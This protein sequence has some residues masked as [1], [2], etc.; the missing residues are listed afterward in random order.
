MKQL[1]EHHSFTG[2]QRDMSISKH[3][4]S[5]LYDAHNI[6][7]TAR[8]EDT[9][10]TITNERGPSYAGVEI[11]GTYLG[12]CLLGKYLVIFS[13][14]GLKEDDN[15]PE[16]IKA[17]DDYIT[18]IDLSTKESVVLYKGNLE[19]DTNHPIETIGSYE[20]DKIQKIYWTDGKNQ[21]R[22]INIVGE[23]KE[24]IDTQFDFI[25]ELALQEEVTIQKQLGS[26]GSFAPGVIQY[27]FTYYNKHG[28]ETNIFYTSPL[29]YISHKDR[30]GSPEDK[31]ENAFKITLKNVDK[32]FDYIRIYSIQRTSIDA[33]PIVK[34]V[35]D[36]NIKAESTTVRSERWLVSNYVKIY[37]GSTELHPSWVWGDDYS[38]LSEK[39]SPLIFDNIQTPSA[40]FTE[41]LYWY[42]FTKSDYP[43]L[44]IR[45]P[46]GSITWEEG[47][48]NDST[49]W[50]SSIFCKVPNATPEDVFG[51][52]ILQTIDSSYT[53]SVD[54]KVH[55]DALDSVSFLDV[56]T[57]GE[58]VD[59]TELLYKGGESIKVQTIDQKDGTLFLGNIETERKLIDSQ[60]KA[61]IKSEAIRIV[62]D[63]V[64]SEVRTFYPTVV[65]KGDYL[66]H[67]QLTSYADSAKTISVPCGGFK[68]GD[69]YRCGVQF[70]Y[71]DGRWS[72]PIFLNDEQVLAKPN[73]DTTND[74]ISVPV[75]KYKIGNTNN[76]LNTLYIAGYRKLRPVVV[77][78]S[79]QDRVTICQG[80]TNP[81]LCFNH[82][83]NGDFHT[84]S[85]VK[86]QSSW[87]F[88]PSIVGTKTS[89]INNNST[90]SPYAGSGDDLE[91][92]NTCEKDGNKFT[93]STDPSYFRLIEIQG[94]FEDSDKLHI[95]SRILSMHSPDIEF[96]DSLYNLNFENTIIRKVGSI[97]FK[98]T[99]SDINIQTE[100]PQVSNSSFGFTHESF[101][102]NGS[103]GIVA[104]LFYEDFALDDADGRIQQWSE[105]HS[106]FKWMVYPWQR[107][108][109]LNNDITR[110]QDKGT[111]TSVLKK[112]VISN[113]RYAQSELADSSNWISYNISGNPQVYSSDQP[114]IVKVNE[115][116][117][118]GNIDTSLYPNKPDGMYF[119]FYSK[120]PT[121]Y[122]DGTPFYTDFGTAISQIEGVNYYP[123]YKTFSKSAENAN[124]QG[125]WR[126][127]GNIA[128]TST[129][130][131]K[132]S[133]NDIGN[134]Y[135]QLAVN[136][137]AVRMRYKSTP[138]L[139]LD[140]GENTINYVGLPIIEIVRQGDNSSSYYRSTMFGGTSEDALKANQWI[141]CGEP[142]AIPSNMSAEE[143]L[144]FEYSY[145]DTYFQRWDCLKTYPFSNDDI[146]QIV[147]IGSFMLETRV[148]ID[149]RYDRNRGQISNL[150]MN[151]VNFNLFNPVYNQTDNFFTYRILDESYYNINKF[152]NQITWTKEKK[153]GA[154]VD[155][156]TN[157]TLASTYDMDGSKG[158]V[159]SLQTWKD[160]IFCFQDLGISNILFNSRVQ[161][162]TSDGVP[163][164]ISNSYKVDGYRYI[165]DGIGCTNKWT[166]SNTPSGLYFADTKTNHLH[167]I[168]S[169]GIQDVTT[170]HNMTSWFNNVNSNRITKTLHDDVNHDLYALTSNESICYSEV[171]GN[172]TSFMSYQGISLIE[173]YENSV[174]T[175]KDG[176]LYSMF[177]GEYNK[178]FGENYEPWD[179]TFISNG[180]DNNLMDFDKVYSTI[181][182]RMDMMSDTDYQH[183]NSLD[184]IRV[185]NEYQDTEDVNLNRNNTSLS[186]WNKEANL[187][188]KFRIWRIQIPRDKKGGN[189]LDRIRN[190]WC[191]IKLGSKGK[192][193]YK[194]VLH[195]L[196]VQYYL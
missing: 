118:Q 150:N 5:F 65:S 18:R 33:V 110:P 116:T 166:I 177:T 184:F 137:Q 186:F 132:S 164:E 114:T 127:A 160:Q 152:P 45:T 70:Q 97:T 136:K 142:V 37:N 4:S 2:M 173:S 103:F 60:T 92:A 3:P 126:F 113:L 61:S 77:F 57:S 157:I 143:Y 87:F 124:D 104:G 89:Y 23:I 141:P 179:F 55:P 21:P 7:L 47:T 9:L 32:S 52:H 153:A 101:I 187:Q 105:Q 165:S 16:N 134:D 107:S 145:G 156:W 53:Q 66:Y 25:R 73:L 163:I 38:V 26:S 112:K 182:Y 196:N 85:I 102:Q 50:V 144:P 27:A 24:N 44:E 46:N 131:W 91:Y 138:H 31:V 149:G 183:D 83:V 122:I 48:T 51:Y 64:D 188:K 174:Y 94:H 181:D 39:N 22:V 34:R 154:D 54:V 56:G 147:E 161:I 159:R 41:D 93:S 109:S 180:I 69:Y 15:T 36:I 35:Q 178:F 158:E 146:N 130:E 84:Y 117:Y 6:R 176:K 71:K 133:N 1:N 162:P 49:I 43:D 151:A 172:F 155:L 20:N 192:N 190:T 17:V 193:N 139:V 195:D 99:F 28:Q 75:I 11:K 115:T 40:S 67:N 170:I 168:G 78:P 90:V 81:T 79:L 98:K 140:L 96:D 13:T 108:G 95:L 8:G 194:A 80:V 62:S 123:F 106:P 191:K 82:D 111:A 88:R 171:L 76:I 175:M 120:N 128:G 74:T 185:Y 167:H 30:G 59:P 72:D 19:F 68:R 29:L 100:T 63:K 135:I 14:K 189:G 121:D 10:L 119:A 86:A 58:A 12:H 129:Y 42:G 169:Q 125:I 148:N